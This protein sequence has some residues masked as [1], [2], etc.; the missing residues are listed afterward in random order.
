MNR[1]IDDLLPAY[2]NGTL[3]N[4]DRVRVDQHLGSCPSCRDV[5]DEWTSIAAATQSLYAGQVPFSGRSLDRVWSEIDAETDSRPQA[6]RARQLAD[7]TQE[8][9]H[10]MSARVLT[11]T[12]YPTPKRIYPTPWIAATAAVLMVAMVAY[13]WFSMNQGGGSGP[14][15]MPAAQ[16]ASNATPSVMGCPDVA[17][18]RN[19]DVTGP[20]ET[21]SVVDLP[22]GP[23]E[24]GFHLRPEALPQGGEAADDATVNGVSET[25][26]QLTACANANKTN[27]SWALTTDDYIRRYIESGREPSEATATSVV[28][29]VRPAELEAPMPEIRNVVVLDDGRVGAEIRPS[30]D[31]A[32]GS[33]DYF[34]FVQQGD[35]WLIDEAVHVQAFVQ[36]EVI[37]NDQGFTP[38]ELTVPPQAAE[39]VLTNE[40]TT[41]HSLIVGEHGIRVEAQPGESSTTSIKAPAGTYY[42][43]SDIAGD[44]PTIFTGI[45][46]F[47]GQ[48]QPEASPTPSDTRSRI[49]EV[50]AASV[51]IRM[52]AP[53][54]YSPDRIAIIAGRDVEVTLVNDGSQD[55]NFTVDELGISVDL[56]AGESE[57]VTINAPQ[58]AY[59]FY[60]TI[61][62][63]AQAG[64][65]GIL[66]VQPASGQP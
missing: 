52:T 12:P 58:G 34:V 35:E 47:E 55:A 43:S 41:T 7:L 27:A 59:A 16:F 14:E 3:G 31:A 21:A 5:L 48:S 20:P 62:G 9:R 26:A 29:M 46:T 25:V 56:A 8:E 57:T 45:I 33:Y 10:A 28:S 2:L 19:L 17:E 49:I 13:A 22:E 15:P 37:V 63:H 60:S 66:F 61:P 65:S 1:H 11:P 54:S 6:R 42:F 40:G 53:S 32:Q 18:G 36:I 39:L 30:F 51:T 24:G 4:E 50:P 44:D 64:M 38:N 23:Y